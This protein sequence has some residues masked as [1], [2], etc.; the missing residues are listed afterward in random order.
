M[1][2]GKS[3]FFPTPEGKPWKTHVLNVSGTMSA[4][5]KTLPQ[6]SLLKSSKRI[7]NGIEGARVWRLA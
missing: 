5:G 7:E 4:V 2:V 6:G 3:K 1:P